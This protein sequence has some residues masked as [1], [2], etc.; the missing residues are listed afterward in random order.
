MKLNW[1]SSMDRKNKP[2]AQ[3]RRQLLRVTA[4]GAASLAAGGMSLAQAAV[5][6]PINGDIL[7]VAII[8]AGLAGL[9]GGSRPQTG[10]M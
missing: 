2:D 5:K 10:R 3:T 9:T 1:A 4:L 7:D 8:G 6:T